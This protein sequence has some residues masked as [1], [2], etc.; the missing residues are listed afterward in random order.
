MPVPV[1]YAAASSNYF[2]NRSSCMSDRGAG[3]MAFTIFSSL[4]LE[5]KQPWKN[6]CIGPQCGLFY[7]VH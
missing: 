2:L 7:Y 4:R 3:S 5:E 6:Q 1:I